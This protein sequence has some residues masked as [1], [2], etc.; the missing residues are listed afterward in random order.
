M[1]WTYSVKWKNKLNIRFDAPKREND[2][3]KAKWSERCT[4]QF[5]VALTN[6]NNVLLFLFSSHT[7]S[8]SSSSRGKWWMWI[9]ALVLTSEEFQL[10]SASY[11]EMMLGDICSLKCTNPLSL[12]DVQCS[13]YTKRKWMYF[14]LSCKIFSHSFQET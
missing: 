14:R 12:Y 7:S 2:V 11:I 5:H 3:R 8:S 1:C 9:E 13:M 6:N 10:Y 4:K